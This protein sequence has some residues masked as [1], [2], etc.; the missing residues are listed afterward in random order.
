MRKVAVHL[1]DVRG[2]HGKRLRKTCHIGSTKTFLLL[3]MHHGNTRILRAESIN[4]LARAIRR[5]V[6]EEENHPLRGQILQHRSS[7]RRDVLPLVVGRYDD[8]RFHLGKLY[9]I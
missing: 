7:H 6:V 5:I 1:D 3:S 2:T 9:H 4:D 8:N